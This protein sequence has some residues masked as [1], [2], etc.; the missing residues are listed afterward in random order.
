MIGYE[1]D[2]SI[3]GAVKRLPSLDS[4]RAYEA[5]ARHLSFTK[6]AEELCVTQSALS[7]RV[8]DLEE[9]L[10]LK[11]FRRLPRRL[12]LS[13]EGETLAEGVRRG[14]AEIHRAL[15]AIDQRQG[16]G[17]LTVSVLPSFASRWLIPR[18]PSFRALHPDI[19]VRISADAAPADLRGGAADLALRFGRGS[20]PGLHVVRLMA[21]AVVP[22]CSP[23]LL[24][25]QAPIV[26]PQDILRLPLLHDVVAAADGSGADW[27][28]WFQ[29]AGVQDVACGDGLRFNQALLTLEAAAN[30][31]GV[32][33]ARRSLI[34]EDLA[35]RRLVEMLPLAAPTSFA[36]FAVCLPEAATRPAV[37]AFLDWLLGEAKAAGCCDAAGSGLEPSCDPRGA[38]AGGAPAPPGAPAAIAG[39]TPA[40]ESSRDGVAPPDHR[41]S[42]HA[43]AADR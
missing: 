11:L 37:A 17:P 16:A 39:A 4:L 34:S 20:Y 35:S 28:S 27:P 22:V 38:E 25:G 29:F 31:L 3:G 7:H 21:D 14:L 43:T 9:E 8:S 33:L 30:G 1:P 13:A 10:G 32:A 40:Q 19:E 23:R 2:S 41:R 12:E 6:A 18:L 24:E 15:A 36:Y 42:R 26:R 5:A